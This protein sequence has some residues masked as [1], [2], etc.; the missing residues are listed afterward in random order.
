VIGSRI[1]QELEASPP[2]SALVNVEKLVSD[3]RH[4]MDA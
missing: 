3:I 4:A 2:E 1:I